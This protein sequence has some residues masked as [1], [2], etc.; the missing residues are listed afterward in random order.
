[1]DLQLTVPVE[2]NSDVMHVVGCGAKVTANAG[3][4][5][6]IAAHNPIFSLELSI[7]MFSFLSNKNIESLS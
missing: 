4:E 7:F 3:A 6:M 5:N 2:E 1:M